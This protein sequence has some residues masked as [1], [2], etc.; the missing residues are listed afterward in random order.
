[1]YAIVKIQKVPKS[2][3]KSANHGFL[4]LYLHSPMPYSAYGVILA[5]YTVVVFVLFYIYETLIII[6]NS[7]HYL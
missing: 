6:F 7:L 2:I 3:D 4:L 1:M 5:K